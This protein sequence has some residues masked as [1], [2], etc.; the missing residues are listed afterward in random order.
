MLRAG[1]ATAAI[2]AV[3]GGCGG[4]VSSGPTTRPHPSAT[5]EICRTLALAATDDARAL[6]RAFG[7]QASP[8][9]LAMYD[10]REHVS[11]LER[12]GCRPAVLG[13]ALRSKMSPREL[14]ALD[15]LLPETYVRDVRQAL[16]CAHGKRPTTRCIAPAAPIHGGRR[17]QARRNIA[18]AGPMSS[19]PVSTR[20]DG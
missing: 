8:G 12:D 9:D 16:A 7:G 11:F 17:G 13:D 19:S 6:V 3:A 10:L 4:H 18:P 1:L 15:A 14:A 5:P 20:R 2:A